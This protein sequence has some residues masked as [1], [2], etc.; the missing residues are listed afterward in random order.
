MTDFSKPIPMTYHGVD[1]RGDYVYYCPECGKGGSY[2]GTGQVHCYAHL[3]PPEKT[4]T[5]EEVRELTSKAF[6]SGA[7]ENLNIFT[8][9]MWFNENVK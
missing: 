7:I 9:D 1:S 5:K 2:M 3:P 6:H 8:F 4:Y